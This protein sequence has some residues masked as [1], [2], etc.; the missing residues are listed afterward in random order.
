MK[1]KRNKV[2]LVMCGLCLAVAFS[3]CSEDGSAGGSSGNGADVV[4]GD[5]ATGADQ[6]GADT[7]GAET[8]MGDCEAPMDV[9]ITS[10]E[11][12]LLTNGGLEVGVQYSIGADKVD[13]MVNGSV[14]ASEAVASGGGDIALT[15][16]PED[17]GAYQLVARASCGAGGVSVQSGVV[18]VD[19]DMTP[20]VIS[21]EL[22]RFVVVQ[23][24]IALPFV[25][26]DA[27]VDRV[28]LL[29]EDDESEIAV[30]SPG[31]SDLLLDTTLY[32][33]GIFP[34]L[35]EV[36][37]L[38]G[39]VTRE[40]L[41]LVITNEGGEELDVQYVPL[42]AVSVPENYA[43][44]E[45]HTRVVINAKRDVKRVLTWVT[46]DASGDWLMEYSTGQGTCPHNGIQYIA[47]QSRAGELVIDLS[48]TELAKEIVDM[49]PEEYQTGD[50]FPH[51]SDPSTF[52]AFFGHVAPM[53]PA[54]HVN[55]SVAIDVGYVVFY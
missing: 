10:P 25:V 14:V 19:I 12:G 31:T 11:N 50:V 26:E 32:D 7:A 36:T 21:H 38:A 1:M 29:A 13:L 45:Y 51:N 28:C 47:E 16:T 22:T 53:D 55:D 34:V 9:S 44:V 33:D 40:P 2:L 42:A 41:R 17:D 5:S 35:V 48:R 54:D 20:P 39:N 15:W 18:S 37:D 46:W 43:E 30:A 4:A 49:F 27:H 23:G 6:G 24:S 8:A 52:G 3:G